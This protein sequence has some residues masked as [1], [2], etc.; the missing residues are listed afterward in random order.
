MPPIFRLRPF[1]HLVWLSIAGLFLAGP[2]RLT[3]AG[4]KD[5]AQG[6]KKPQGTWIVVRPGQSPKTLD[7]QHQ[8]GLLRD[9]K[10]E[11]ICKLDGDRLTLC[12]AEADSGK[13][14]PDEF[15]TR[16]GSCRLLIVVE[17]KKP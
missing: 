4:D 17:R 9:K 5:T 1:A 3:R 7:F 15:A 6:L 12:Y 8:E 11:G 10:W 16:E 13:D 2:C 14:R